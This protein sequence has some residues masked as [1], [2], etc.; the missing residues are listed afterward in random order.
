MATRFELVQYPASGSTVYN[1]YI[2]DADFTGTPSQL[3]GYFSL[4]YQDVDDSDPLYPI[5]TSSVE[6]TIH[7]GEDDTDFESFLNE[8]VGSDE[9][10]FQII[11]N[12]NGYRIWRGHLP[13]DLLEIPDQ[14]YTF[15][16]NLTASDGLARLKTIEYR[17]SSNN[18]FTGTD[19]VAKHLVN[20]ISKIGYAYS[21]AD[22]IICKTYAFKWKEDSQ[23]GSTSV[24]DVWRIQHSLFQE[25]ST[26]PDLICT[27]CYEIL[28]NLLTSFNARIMQVDGVFVIQQINE[29]Y[30]TYMTTWKYDGT[31]LGFELVDR[32]T[33][34][35]VNRSDGRFIFYPAVRE[36][37]T[38]YAYK[39]SI[40]KN[41]LLPSPMPT[42]V[43]VPIGSF[44]GD[45]NHFIMNVT[46]RS[47]FNMD[48]TAP[49]FA[50][51]K[52]MVRVGT[53]TIA[54]R[55]S[56]F[57]G[58]DPMS[59]IDGYPNTQHHLFVYSPYATDY[60][61][62][63]VSFQ[64][65]TPAFSHSG[66]GYVYI[67][68]VGLYQTP[69]ISYP[70]ST[71]GFS[72]NIE[73]LQMLQ[74][75]GNITGTAGKLSYRAI[76]M[77]SDGVT[78]IN[79]SV[80]RELD[81]SSIGD[82]PSSFSV[83]KIQILNTLSQWVDSDL[84][85]PYSDYTGAA[86]PLHKLRLLEYLALNKSTVKVFEFI[87]EGY[88]KPYNTVY[89]EGEEYL[90]LAYK[91]NPEYDNV[92]ITC[93][94]LSINR[95]N[96]QLLDVVQEESEGGSGGGGGYGNTPN[97]EFNYWLQNTTLNELQ[98]KNGED[99]NL[100]GRYI[101]A[102]VITKH[103]QI[104]EEGGL[105]EFKNADRDNTNF[106]TFDLA[107]N[108]A[109]LSNWLAVTNYDSDP[110]PY[111]MFEVRGSQG[112]MVIPFKPVV[113]SVTLTLGN[114]HYT[115]L[116]DTTTTAGTINLPAANTVPGRIYKIR[117]MWRPGTNNITIDPYS[118]ENILGS[119]GS[120]VTLILDAPGEWVTLQS[121][122]TSGAT[123]TWCVIDSSPTF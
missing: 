122:N 74:L 25:Y 103:I 18:P 45:D 54:G 48:L 84:W 70:G 43:E 46:I 118:T 78:P 119:V 68:L 5:I 83:S 49:C 82:G 88:C 91:L 60:S 59:W 120:Y 107:T 31:S 20:I 108:K 85:K 87:L 23:Y 40:N 17:D 19:T 96:I 92:E 14:Y 79:S 110:A 6:I 65:I 94:R 12:R 89:F 99:V 39:Y 22:P 47:N 97:N 10:R 11:I 75:Q 24:V 32:R 80:T 27:N 61:T 101:T 53:Y 93:M 102:N 58:N 9:M 56:T 28:T 121:C 44:S 3:N 77:K 66:N 2:T 76:N 86:L 15:D 105:L 90:I 114:Q 109:K 38:S 71:N 111:S 13:T 95:D 29:Y 98:P 33:T 64:V 26:Y 117:L 112:A 113:G 55:Y 35:T 21:E 69:D 115:I 57:F 37:K 123:F 52:I 104:E 51:Y 73:Q 16:V 36:V 30:N 116:C 50:V 100:N 4:P 62:N 7:V 67:E 41:N 81:N 42:G 8:L 1:L 34:V 106:L 72:Y 63:V